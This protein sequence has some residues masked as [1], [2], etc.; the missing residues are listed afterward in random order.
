[1][2]EHFTYI[3]LIWQPYLFFHIY[4]NLCILWKIYCQELDSVCM[5]LYI[6]VCVH[7]YIHIYIHTVLPISI[8]PC[9]H[10]CLPTS[11]HPSI[12]TDSCIYVSQG[13]GFQTLGSIVHVQGT[14]HQYIS[15]QKKTNNW[16]LLLTFIWQ[17]WSAQDVYKVCTLNNEEKQLVSCDMLVWQ[18]LQSNIVLF[19]SN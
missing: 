12:C 7:T 2:I 6:Y 15:N 8:H 3:F 11:I 17:F 5:Y 19:K 14:S 4:G 9:I 18:Q 16:A 1:M 13:C 10:T